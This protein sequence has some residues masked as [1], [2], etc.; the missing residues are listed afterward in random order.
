MQ[1]KLPP[2]QALRVFECAA[3]HEHFTLAAEELHVTH[4]AVSRQVAVLEDWLGVRV[5]HRRGKRVQLT[6]D[7]RRYLV[8]VQA[9][10]DSVAAASARLA[11]SGTVRT[12][13]I[14]ALATFAMRWLLPRLSRF[15]RLYPAVELKLATSNTALTDA[16]EVFD[17]AVRRGP[18]HWANC[19]SRE[20]MQETE[21]PVCSPALMELSPIREPADLR[22]HTL[23]HSDTRPDA[24]QKWLVSA[25]LSPQAFGKRQFFD[26][27][28]LALQAAA[29]GLGVALGPL[30]LILDEIDSGRLVV[31]LR[32]PDV[33]ARSYWWIVPRQHA[34]QPL[35]RD[36]CKWLEDEARRD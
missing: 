10:F 17:V 13:R 12:L 29:D 20:F 8:T 28:Y 4:G 7:G 22:H 1:R 35:V 27:Y 6:D 15:Q 31:A 16:S 18:G 30:P 11:E 26:H 32:K 9:A 3:R 14:N 23:L 5:F 25:G 21:V 33:P 24:W 19:D 36:F 34:T 2:L